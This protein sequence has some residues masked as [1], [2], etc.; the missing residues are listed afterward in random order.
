M[1]YVPFAWAVCMKHVIPQILLVLF[2][3]LAFAR[4]D[5]G[6]WELGHYGDYLSWPFQIV[7]ASGVFIAITIVVAGISK[8]DLFEGLVA[9]PSSRQSDD[10]SKGSSYQEMTYIEK[11]EGGTD[12]IKSDRPLS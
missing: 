4:T 8:P 12:S 9:T 6:K 2:F 1:G 3:N 10:E 11:S 7:G 5:Y